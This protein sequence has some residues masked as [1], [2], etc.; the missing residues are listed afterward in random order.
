[1]PTVVS[2]GIRSLVHVVGARSL[3]HLRSL[4]RS[5]VHLRFLVHVGVAAMALGALGFERQAAGSI[6]R[7]AGDI[8]AGRIGVGSRVRIA[9][10]VTGRSTDGS[11]VYVSDASRAVVLE[12]GDGLATGQRVVVEAQPVRVDGRLRF[13]VLRIVGSTPGIPPAATPVAPIEVTTGRAAGRR[14]ELTGWVQ[15]VTD[16]SGV[17][18]MHLSLQARHVEAYVPRV[19]L[20]ELRRHM[21]NM[22]RVR[23]LVHEPRR[24][25]T[26]EAVGRISVDA[27]ED[28]VPVGR[29]LAAPGPRRRL[30]TIA[31]ARAL[32]PSDAAAAHEVRVIGRATFVHAAW[33][34]LFVQDQTA[35]IFVLVTENTRAPKVIQ[36]GDELRWRAIPRPATSRRSS[37]PLKCA[38]AARGHCPGRRPRASSPW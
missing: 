3:A 33:N 14:V 34:S 18:S 12:R 23:A 11:L 24:L 29:Q 15:S 5:L 35:G 21:G 13:A 32:R 25:T 30:T 9:G 16:A 31:E 10:T 8:E 2:M 19:P 37:P 36:P 26:S 22:V 1:M 38:T 4:V 20:A 7:L 17:P 6:D 27:A 28:I